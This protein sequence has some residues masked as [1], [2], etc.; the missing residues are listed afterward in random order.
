METKLCMRCGNTKSIDQFHKRTKPN[1]I[2]IRQARCKICASEIAQKRYENPAY[3][4]AVRDRA[5]LAR[6]KS[7]E[8][9]FE[10]LSEG[11]ID[12]KEKDIRCLEFDHVTEKKEQDISVMRRQGKGQS[13]IIEE[14]SK[15]V[16]RCANCHR[17]R[18]MDTIPNCWRTK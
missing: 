12:C 8:I 9:M 3:R 5:K 1:K 16:V 4:K 18:T 17:K 6:I 14:I 7:Q 10:K 13:K 11:C 15:C 2:V